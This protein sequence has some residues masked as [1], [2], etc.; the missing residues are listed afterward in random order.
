MKFARVIGNLVAR[1]AVDLLRAQQPDYLFT[2][3]DE[4]RRAVTRA[5]P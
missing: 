1:T 3:M 5:S 4:I 2:S